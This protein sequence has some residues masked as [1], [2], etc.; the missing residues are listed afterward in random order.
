[1]WG[2]CSLFPCSILLP[3][4]NN[5]STRKSLKD[6]V[7]QAPMGSLRVTVCYWLMS[8]NNRKLW[9]THFDSLFYVLS[10]LNGSSSCCSPLA[11][12][13]SLPLYFI[14]LY[15]CSHLT[16]PSGNIKHP[17]QVTQAQ[18]QHQGTRGWFNTK[19]LWISN[20][21]LLYYHPENNAACCFHY[22]HLFQL[23]E[24]LSYSVLMKLGL[25]K[26]SLNVCYDSN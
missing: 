6:S 10:T 14:S 23:L 13:I 12:H 3:G 26:Y 4:N 16:L 11:S 24:E 25:K 18:E 1:M 22:N 19:N 7:L 15:G 8:R 5:H 17:P 2:C 20:I 9:F 21:H